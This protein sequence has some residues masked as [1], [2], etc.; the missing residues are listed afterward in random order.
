VNLRKAILVLTAM[1]ALGVATPALANLNADVNSA[2]AGGDYN[3]VMTA[4][5]LGANPNTRDRVGRT[6]LGWAARGG[7]TRVAAYLLE[8]GAAINAIDNEGYTPL[9]WAAR[10]GQFETVALLVS[11]GAN[12]LVRN[13][14]GQDALSL[15]HASRE[16]R[17]QDMIYRY[18]HG[19]TVGQA[20]KPHRQAPSMSGMADSSAA[21][22]PIAAK[23]TA[24]RPAAIRPTP[25]KPTPLPLPAAALPAPAAMAVPQPV[26]FVPAPAG[27]LPVVVETVAAPT[28]QEPNLVVKAMALKKLA[29]AAVRANTE[30]SNFVKANSSN[31]MSLMDPDVLLG[32]ELVTMYANLTKT[33]SLVACRT[34]F[35]RVKTQWAGRATS[36]FAQNIADV[37]AIL[38]EAGL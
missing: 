4:L 5:Q 8:H 22:Q 15:A 28:P 21:A 18:L 3:G 7:Y 16:W 13:A 27:Q 35:T 26:A 14:Q 33:Q 9:M 17:S 30:L 31:P 24:A 23:P 37:D 19:Q 34:D 1:T 36:R 25:P 10:A 12:P 11:H 20:P 32:K 2:A 6:P 38:K 29:E